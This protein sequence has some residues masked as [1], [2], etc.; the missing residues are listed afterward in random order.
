MLKEGLTDALGDAA[1]SLAVDDQRV[2]RPPHIIDRGVA[3]DFDKAHFRI[4]LDLADV[5]AIGEARLIDGLIAF[6]DQWPAKIFRQIG[7]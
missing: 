2:H 7:T 4:Y 1:M 6:A 3:N 5:A